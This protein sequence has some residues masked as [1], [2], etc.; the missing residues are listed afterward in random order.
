MFKSL[1][2]A[3]LLASGVNQRVSGGPSGGAAGPSVPSSNTDIIVNGIVIGRGGG[4]DPQTVVIS[5]AGMSNN[6]TGIRNVAIGDLALAS[7]TTGNDNFALGYS[8]LKANTTGGNNVAIG[9][10]A[11]TNNTTADDSVAIGLFALYNMVSGGHSVA[12]GD[13]A[14][15]ENVSGGSNVAIG[16]AALRDNL[17]S[18]SVG[19]GRY[20]NLVNVN[21]NQNVWMGAYVAEFAQHSSRTVGLGYQANYC[22]AEDGGDVNCL[23]TDDNVMAGWESAR[24]NRTGK[25]N[26][27][28]GS[29]AGV[30]ANTDYAIV[31][32]NDGV[33]LGYRATKSVI[34]AT[35]LNHFSCLGSECQVGT[36]G[37]LVLGRPDGG[38]AV[39]IGG[40][41]KSGTDI[42][43]V[44]GTIRA[45]NLS[46]VNTGDN[47]PIDCT[48]IHALQYTHDGGWTCL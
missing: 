42:L 8:A 19:I 1:L 25:R 39:V 21:G 27:L 33:L 13:D 15:L 10:E 32:D 24:W 9:K 7:N 31:D 22:Y 46:G 34:Q 17:Q 3:A 37:T 6:T 47:E 41:S 43:Q 5:T 26:V 45:T 12:I 30:G 2:I 44:T 20:A 4:Q 28:M 36:S 14:L 40:T 18:E 38:D 48:G 35:A 23:N 29:E 11:L 16:E